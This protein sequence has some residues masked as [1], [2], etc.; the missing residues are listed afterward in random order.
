MKKYIALFYENSNK[1]NS[2]GVFTLDKPIF[3]V[4]NAN[5]LDKAKMKA[6]EKEKT[7][8]STCNITKKCRMICSVEEEH[9]V[10]EAFQW[11]ASWSADPER[12]RRL[13]PAEANAERVHARW[14]KGV[15]R[16]VQEASWEDE[17]YNLW[18]WFLEKIIFKNN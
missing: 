10:Q 5:S 16:A 12:R 4:I 3:V 15:Q 18:A 8:L 1:P 13:L 11:W 2:D 17:A 7:S 6:V 9:E 14:V